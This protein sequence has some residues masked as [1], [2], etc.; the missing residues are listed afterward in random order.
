MRIADCH[1]TPVAI[2]DPPLLNA[3]GLHAPYALRLII[4]LVSDDGIS[5]WGEIPGS[6]TTRVALAQAAERI[7]G[8]DPW[9]LN[10]IF[11]RIDKLAQP[12][13]RG[14]TPWDNRAWVHVRSAIEVACYDLL[15]KAVGRPVVD[16]LG[17]AV[18]ERVPFAA[19]LFY[20]RAGAGGE[21]GFERDPSAT[22]WRAARA[23]AALDPAGIVAQ[24]QAM[25][26]H[27]GFR[28]I[29][30]KGGVFPPDEEVAAMLALREAFGADI[31]LR[32]DPN[33]IWRVD[34]AI[35]V[36]KKLLGVL[37]YLE[38]PV[39]GQV[40]MA[41]VARELETPLATN[42]CT[43]SFADLPGSI[44]RASEAIIL[45]DHHFWGG[46]RASLGLARVCRV[47]GRGLSMHSNSHL[48][49]SLAAM[50]HLA[51]ATPNDLYDCDT[52]YPWQD[53]QDLLA[54]PL[55]FEDGSIMLPR[56]P[57]L[58]IEVDRERLAQ[59]HQNYLNCGLTERNDEIEMQKLKPG[60][61]FQAT[62]W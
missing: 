51:A 1:I 61:E 10:A 38:D 31:P 22:G 47:F 7:I 9:Q 16:L 42:M 2:P 34:T 23:E 8:G 21:F 60:W 45:S 43:T 59:L 57:G 18:R 52:H 41:A 28:S 48:G 17:G 62:R 36:G 13:E 27:Y 40:N 12:D 49:I 56:E 53:G 33:A 25:C 35:A 15:G 3:A 19:Y 32:L 46:L 37:E 55:P 54:K 4:E 20:K 29:K 6:E 58:G 50:A 11:A 14:A 5:G 26:S 24:A 44:Q 39:R 30:L